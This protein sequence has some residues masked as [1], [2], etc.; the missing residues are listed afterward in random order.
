MTDPALKNSDEIWAEKGAFDFEKLLEP[1]REGGQRDRPV[2]RT[3]GIM[4]DWLVNKKQYPVEVVGGAILIVFWEMFKGKEFSG[5]EKYGS[6]GRELDQYVRITCDKL[7]NQKLQDKVFASIAGG[8]MAMI[9]EFINR[10]VA[11]KTYPRIKKIF[12]RS[13]WKAMQAEYNQMVEKA[14]SDEPA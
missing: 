8:R 6:K 3:M 12:C 10:E 2:K 14:K 4:I 7:L 5:D 9:N 11:I 1:Y 13:K